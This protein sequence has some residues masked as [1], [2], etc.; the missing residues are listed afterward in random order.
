MEVG[1]KAAKTVEEYW[2]WYA[3]L[4]MMAEEV[5]VLSG[6]CRVFFFFFQA[7]DGIRDYKVTGVQTCALPIL[8]SSSSP[9]LT[10]D[11]SA[12]AVNATLRERAAASGTIQPAWL[13]PT[14][15][16]KKKLLY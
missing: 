3:L 12:R 1:P 11:A 8:Y 7:E 15:S 16:Q 6:S 4:G 14:V 10:A 2:V 13:A 5:V 9:W